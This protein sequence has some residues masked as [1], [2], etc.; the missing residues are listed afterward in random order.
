MATN[1]ILRIFFVNS[2]QE[3]ADT[4]EVP[5]G[6]EKLVDHG[7][8]K[9]KDKFYTFQYMIDG[10]FAAQYEETLIL[11]VPEGFKDAKTTG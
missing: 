10:E 7:I 11:E 1:P 5:T 2:Q 4:L 6:V 3:L 8:L 9:F